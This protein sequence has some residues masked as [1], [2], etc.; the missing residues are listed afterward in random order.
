MSSKKYGT[1]HIGLS[2]ENW[3]QF[4]KLCKLLN[5]F[6]RP[7][8]SAQIPLLSIGE[9]EDEISERTTEPVIEFGMIATGFI[10]QSKYNIVLNSKWERLIHFWE[11]ID[12]AF[13]FSIGSKKVHRIGSCVHY[14]VYCN[15]TLVRT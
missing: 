15:K 14:C 9:R 2:F 6:V 10:V 13:S 1:V 8:S 5:V 11:C 7:S 4:R 12:E 3:C